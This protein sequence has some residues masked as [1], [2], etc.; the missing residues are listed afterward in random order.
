MFIILTQSF[1]K[2]MSKIKISLRI[3]TESAVNLN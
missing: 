3:L 1:M 2:R